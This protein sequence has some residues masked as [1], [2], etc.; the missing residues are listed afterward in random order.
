MTTRSFLPPPALSAYVSSILMIEYSDGI[1]G[2]HIPLFANGAPTIIFQSAKAVGQNSYLQLYGQTVKP[3]QLSFNGPVTLIAYFLY[4]H[5]PKA[6]LGI[7]ATELTDRSINLHEVKGLKESR[8]QE[9]LLN[10]QSLPG[11]LKLMDDLILKLASADRFDAAKLTFATQHLKNND[12]PD[13]LLELRRQ[14]NISER[15]LQRLFETNIGLSPKMFRRV[16]Q[17]HS[18]FQ[19]LNHHQFEKLT[20]IAYEHGFADQSHFIRV[21]KE[22]TNLTPKEYLQK[23]APYDPKF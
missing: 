14:L 10:E 18:A 22:F 1:P 11:R 20:D 8:L 13:A 9:R 15:S 21:F 5:V 6:F 19:Q 2:F 16:W 23:A 17:F 3:A 7:D 12:A 4:P